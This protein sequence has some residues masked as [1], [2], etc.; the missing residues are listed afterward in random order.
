MDN[1]SK[2]LRIFNIVAIAVTAVCIISFLSLTSVFPRS[3]GYSTSEKRPLLTFPTYSNSALFDGSYTAGIAEWYTDTVPHREELLG[4]AAGIK[5]LYGVD[6]YFQSSNL[7]DGI[8]D[9]R[10]DGDVSDPL[11]D[12]SE[13]VD[14]DIS[15]GDISYP[16]GFFELD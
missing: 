2:F 3:E 16:D 7:Q 4:I 13:E 6:T 12:Y 14:P 15:Y 1:R 11:A 8:Q 5:G 10:P 9:S